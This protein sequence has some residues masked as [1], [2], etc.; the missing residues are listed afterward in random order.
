MYSEPATVLS[1]LHE[2]NARKLE[3]RS[4]T[5]YGTSCGLFQ[6]CGKPVEFVLLSVLLD[7]GGIDRLQVVP[8]FLQTIDQPVPV[9]C[10]FHG[11]TLQR[12][13]VRHQ[14]VERQRQ[15]IA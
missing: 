12:I 14:R 7:R 5:V 10:R 9:E 2:V 11:D 1:E 6:G 13:L 4:D 15:V 8:L 3:S